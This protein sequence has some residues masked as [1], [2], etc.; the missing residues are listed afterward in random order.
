MT[1]EIDLE[2]AHRYFSASCF[3]L[4]WDY[5]DKQART[6]EEDL[7]M[8]QA[9]MASFWHWTQRP[10]HTS[11]NLSIGYWQLSR[12]F[13]LLKQVDL[14]R[15]YG[16]LCLQASQG[17]GELPFFLGYAYEALARTEAL[18]GNSSKR[19]EYLRQAHDLSDRVTDLEDRQRLLD[20]LR[21]IQ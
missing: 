18:A 20:D 5:I 1:T 14:A 13:A 16:I 7:A 21:S 12:I 3:N 11:R 9:G 19:D 10:D 8:L 15:Q 2:K 4:A 17:E 6:A